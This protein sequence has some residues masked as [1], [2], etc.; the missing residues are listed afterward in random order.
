LPPADAR[1]PQIGIGRSNDV[2]GVSSKAP[3]SLKSFSTVKSP[4]HVD[5]DMMIGIYKNHYISMI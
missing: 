4:P 5:G 3:A 1:R 2:A